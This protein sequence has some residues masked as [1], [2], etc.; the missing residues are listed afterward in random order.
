MSTSQCVAD[1]GLVDTAPEGAL[2]AASASRLLKG[3][4]IGFAVTV[5][6][7]LGLTSWYVGSRIVAANTLPPPS[8]HLPAITPPEPSDAVVQPA[9]P[10][11]YLQVAGL[12]PVRDLSFVQRLD[13][14]G[15]RARVERAAT[16]A[17]TRI[18]IGPF[19]ERSS[20]EEAEHRLQSQGVLAM[21]AVH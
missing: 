10:A 15:Y 12:G 2:K 9:L 20:L 7:G 1:P 3:L 14:Q 4:L 11:L 21:E 13:A 8:L 16:Q 6:I 18:L 17:D 19:A 5:T